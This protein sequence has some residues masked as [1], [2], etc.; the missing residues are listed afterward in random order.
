MKKLKENIPFTNIKTNHS[1][2]W[3]SENI[4]DENL[5]IDDKVS[6]AK[7]NIDARITA[8]ENLKIRK[9]FVIKVM[10][11]AAVL[12][13]IATSTV[14]LYQN[15][16]SKKMATV[17]YTT[18][19]TSASKRKKVVLIDGTVVWLNSKSAIS[20]NNHFNEKTRDI[21]LSGEAFFEVT[22]NKDIPFFVNSEGVRTKVLGTSFNIEAYPEDDNVNVALIT[23]KIWIKAPDGN[24][25][26]LVP[27]QCISYSKSK[28][29]LSPVHIENLENYT[30]W[31]DGKIVFNNI[32][33]GDACKKLER[34]FNVSIHIKNKEIYQTNINGNFTVDQQP[35]A[36]LEIL[37]RLVG[38]RYRIDNRQ[39]SIS[40]IK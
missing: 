5:A 20:F 30:A 31:K 7:K 15:M 6:N 33:F 8:F 27:N 28:N 29:H 1:Y 17:T 34:L 4:I 10:R 22:K 26:V 2:E 12:V 32:A 25:K 37:C 14:F 39:I 9:L 36:V 23:G 16:V 3:P 35:K 13:I 38:A 19:K 18:I 11:V 24:S 40:R 21:T